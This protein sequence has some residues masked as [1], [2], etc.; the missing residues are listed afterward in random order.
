VSLTHK[1][2]VEAI[3]EIRWELTA[4]NFPPGATLS[5]PH[6][7]IMVGVLR[8]KLQADFPD[9]VKLAAGQFPGMMMPYQVQYQ[10]RTS[11]AGWPLVQLGNGVI[12][13]ND[14]DGYSSDAFVA[15]CLKVVGVLKEFWRENNFNGKISSVGLRYV[16]ADILNG[17]P[18]EDFLKQLDVSVGFGARIHRS[19]KM[20]KHFDALQLLTRIKSTEPPGSVLFSFNRGLKEDK[21]SLIWETAILSEGIE[22]ATFMESPK[23]WLDAAHELAHE[24]FFSMIEGELREKY[25]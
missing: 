9:Y 8:T 25:K 12:T 6:Y 11:G 24:L 14:T 20:G 4:H 7:E 1:P 18:V 13:I 17:T 15:T 5:D 22:C 21:D 10:F 23:T 19:N 3:F 16:D 2:L